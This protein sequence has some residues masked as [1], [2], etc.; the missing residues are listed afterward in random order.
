[1]KAVDHRQ[2]QLRELARS[3]RLETALLSVGEVGEDIITHQRAK[4]LIAWSRGMLTV[5]GDG[6]VDIDSDGSS[7]I[8]NKTAGLGV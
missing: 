6:D 5:C 1:M 7:R 2:N 8:A 4:V 3:A